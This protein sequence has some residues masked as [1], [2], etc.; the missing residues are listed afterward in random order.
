MRSL[1][2]QLRQAERDTRKIWGFIFARY[3][4]QRPAA[5]QFLE[6]F[7]LWNLYI[8]DFFSQNIPKKSSGICCVREYVIVIISFLQILRYFTDSPLFIIFRILIYIFMIVKRSPSI[9][10][11]PTH[12]IL[13]ILYHKYT[14][15]VL[16]SQTP[17]MTFHSLILLLSTSAKDLSSLHL[18]NA[19]NCSSLHLPDAPNC[20]SLHL[21]DDP[22]C[23]YL[24]LPDAPN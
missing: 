12:L 17:F 4:G 15:L 23:S 20:S 18:P 10:L 5:L 3:R 2:S 8:Q 6:H 13:W 16:F 7:F 21:P 14:I 22:N 19:L 11:C 9:I 24:H 1:F